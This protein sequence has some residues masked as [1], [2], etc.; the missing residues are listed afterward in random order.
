MTAA[1]LVVGFGMTTAA[2]AAVPKVPVFL[3]PPRSGQTP[4]VRPPEIVYTGD[5][6]GF[7]AGRGRAGYHPKFGHLHWTEWTATEAKAWGA[8]WLDNCNP[9]CAGGY[10]KPF[11]VNL[12][13]YRPRR[14]LGYLVFT[15]IKVT[16]TK[17][18]EPYTHRHV[19]TF[20]LG[21][22]YGQYFWKFR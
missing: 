18:A 17:K 13:L 15:R 4:R 11:P 7:F 22:G 2:F 10:R 20:R 5:G 16:Y 3:G 8:D 21:V 14:T 12:D 1:A 6:T 9:D 19:E